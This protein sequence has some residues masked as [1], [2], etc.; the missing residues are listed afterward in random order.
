MEKKILFNVHVHFCC[1][2]NTRTYIYMHADFNYYNDERAPT[3]KKKNINIK[4]HR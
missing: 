2:S 3:I 1:Y 4:L